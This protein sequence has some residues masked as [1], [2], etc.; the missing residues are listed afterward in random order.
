MVFSS[1]NLGLRNQYNTII[2]TPYIIKISAMIILWVKYDKRWFFY[3][4]FISNTSVSATSRYLHYGEAP[5]RQEA[6]LEL[7]P[8]AESL[9][10]EDVLLSAKYLFSVEPQSNFRTKR[11]YMYQ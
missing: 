2:S 9:P 5:V 10:V 4:V 1:V 8:K 3:S 11:V 6:L 7:I